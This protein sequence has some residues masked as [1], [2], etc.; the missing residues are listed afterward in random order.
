MYKPHYP[1]Y[2]F[3]QVHKEQ[4]CLLLHYYM[5]GKLKTNL[6]KLRGLEILRSIHI[7][8]HYI[9]KITRSV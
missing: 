8:E 2:A 9:D 7:M 5:S 1:K 6:N 4:E 3:M